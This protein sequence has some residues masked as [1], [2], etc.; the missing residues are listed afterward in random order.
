MRRSKIKVGDVLMWSPYR[1]WRQHGGKPVTVVATGGYLPSPHWAGDRIP[2]TLP[3]GST[4][5]LRGEKNSES[6]F[7]LVAYE[8]HGTVALDFVR[9]RALH[10][11]YDECQAEVEATRNAAALAQDEET[12]R[13]SRRDADVRDAAARLGVP[14][15]WT[16]HPSTDTVAIKA[17][18]LIMLAERL[19]TSPTNEPG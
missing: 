6:P 2:V 9:P 5:E 4:V 3:D 17:D 13:I 18:D 14:E 11:P 15:P 10:G 8:R 16:Y 19:T 1:D 7:V 12:A